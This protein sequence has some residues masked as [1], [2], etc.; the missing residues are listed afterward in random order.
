MGQTTHGGSATPSFLQDPGIQAMST[1]KSAL[2]RE[3]RAA[4]REHAR[5]LPPQVRAL[6]LHRPPGPVLERIPAGAVIGL[7][8]ALTDEAPAG[9]YARF[10]HEGGHPIA[11]PWFAD[12]DAPMLFREHSDPFAQSDLSPGP[13]GPQPDAGADQ[14]MPDVVFVPLLGFTT[15]GDRLG[16]GGG[17]YDRWLD[18][19]PDTIRIGLAW[20][21]QEVASLPLEPH[22]VALDLI[23][24]PTRVIGPC[25]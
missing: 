16:Q 14:L 10:F 3:L 24:T 4:R 1:Q 18:A 20:D 6:I 22:D 23:V 7:Y 15:R 9:G 12:R 11:L 2:R 5:A 25:R 8:E 17:H 21:A 13:F 19:H